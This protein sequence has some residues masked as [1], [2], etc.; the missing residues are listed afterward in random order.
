MSKP[1]VLLSFDVEEFDLPLEFGREISLAE[2]CRLGTEGWARVLDLLAR[3]QVIATLFTTGVIAEYAPHLLKRS[4]TEGHEIASHSFY[5]SAFTRA[6]LARS[7]ATLAALSG[8]EVVGFRRPRFASTPLAW[9]QEAG[10]AYDSSDNPTWV[11]GRYCRW[12]HPRR[13]YTREGVRVIPLST[14]PVFRLP[15]F[16]LSFKNL[17]LPVY[18]A[19]ADWTL[20]QD[21][22]LA[23]VF[24]PWEFLSLASYRLPRYIA[25]GDGEALGEKLERF[26]GWLKGRAEFI[27]YREFHGE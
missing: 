1:R 2:Q 13:P 10:Y 5:H 4:A 12:H 17:P 14:T 19:L 6:D 16:W 23:L 3:Q 15:L 24:H 21:G 9:I 25:S 22:H 7:R 26:L 27:S 11:P 20:R 8:Q 18:Q